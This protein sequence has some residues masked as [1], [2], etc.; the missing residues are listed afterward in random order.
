MQR[1]ESSSKHF[2]AMI[3][4]QEEG[5]SEESMQVRKIFTMDWLKGAQLFLLQNAPVV[6]A[7]S[8]QPLH[9]EVSAVPELC[10]WD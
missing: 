1:S 9:L 2:G 10:P 5:T 8:H 6:S 4:Q 7:F 3:L